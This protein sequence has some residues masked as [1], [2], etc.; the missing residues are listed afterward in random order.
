M[1]KLLLAAATITCLTSGTALAQLQNGAG[2][3][4]SSNA[5]SKKAQNYT[6][7]FIKNSCNHPIQ[8]GV[9]FKNLSNKWQTKAWYAFAPNEAVGRLNGVETRNRYIYYYAETTDESELAW[10]GNYTQLINNRLYQFQ[11]INTGPSIAR[12]TQT[13]TCN[14][15]GESG[16][17]AKELNKSSIKSKSKS[18]TLLAQ[19]LKQP[20]ENQQAPEELPPP[21]SSP[22]SASV[23][24]PKNEAVKAPANPKGLPP[25]KGNADSAEQTPAQPASGSTPAPS[26]EVTPSSTDSS[27]EVTPSSTDSSTPAP[28]PEVT[29][30]STDSSTP[31]PTSE[32][33]PS[34]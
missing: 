27:T 15:A 32:Q 25:A 12:W 33:A 30:S 6:T 19:A 14:N 8:V 7:L 11:E 22:T 28:S 2:G 23:D 17:D 21:V 10:T 31:A 24:A 34:Q 5:G 29:P 26:P 4:G 3:A 16:R 20:G 9:Y 18:G 1:L 13:L